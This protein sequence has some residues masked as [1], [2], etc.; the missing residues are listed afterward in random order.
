[1]SRKNT[2]FKSAAIVSLLMCSNVM[3]QSGGGSTVKPPLNE[4][5]PMQSPGSAP[6]TSNNAPKPSTSNAPGTTTTMT[7]DTCSKGHMSSMS[8]TKAEFDL[9]CKDIR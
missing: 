4:S 2:L 8:M 7:R 6:G 3:A 1:M 9:S 5:T